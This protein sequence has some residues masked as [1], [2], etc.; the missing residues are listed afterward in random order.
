MGEERRKEDVEDGK[1]TCSSGAGCRKEALELSRGCLKTFMQAVAV[2]SAESTPW[3]PS[4][5]SWAYRCFLWHA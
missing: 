4:D 3:Q 5:G 1:D 2:Y